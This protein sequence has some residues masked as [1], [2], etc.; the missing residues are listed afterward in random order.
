MLIN[1]LFRAEWLLYVPTAPK[2]IPQSAHNVH[3]GDSHASKNEQQP[4]SEKC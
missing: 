4:F 2:L 3:R 1:G